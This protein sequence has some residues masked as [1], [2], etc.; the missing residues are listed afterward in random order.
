M[1]KAWV[2]RRNTAIFLAPETHSLLEEGVDKN[3]SDP[4]GR[5][6]TM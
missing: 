4:T 1:Y 2:V 5:I 6:T 3:Y